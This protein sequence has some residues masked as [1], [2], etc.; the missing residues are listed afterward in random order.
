MGFKDVAIDD[1]YDGQAQHA[2]ETLQAKYGIPVDGFVGPLTKIILYKEKDSF[3][4]PQ[5]TPKR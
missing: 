1:K 2:V 4:M 3:D 5:L